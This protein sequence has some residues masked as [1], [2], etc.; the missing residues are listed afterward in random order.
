MTGNEGQSEKKESLT[1]EKL[2]KNF[3]NTVRENPKIHIYSS[4]TGLRDTIT[5]NFECQI[6][7]IKLVHEK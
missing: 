2:E 3:T 1:R 7:S 5:R 4:G 6:P